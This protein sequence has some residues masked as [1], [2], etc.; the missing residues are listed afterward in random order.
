M[1]TAAELKARQAGVKQRYRDDPAAAVTPLR[2]GG[3]FADPG[4]TC[5]VR[6]FA[7][8]VRAGLHPATGGDGSDAC[9]GDMLL[10]A[11]AACAGVT[12]RSVATAMALPITG[13]EV[14]A[15]GTFDAT[16][17]LGIDRTADVGI[18]PITVTITVT[19]SSDVDPAA[20][21]KLADLT[22]RYCV[23]GQSL[24]HPPAIRVVRAG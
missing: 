12:C 7:G 14:E 19:T 3:S 4:I 6:T 18:S 1:T 8:P 15:T 10:E 2:G 16:G 22:E 21:T 13:A 17:T 23:V 24:R 5:T 20:L 9:S 11:L